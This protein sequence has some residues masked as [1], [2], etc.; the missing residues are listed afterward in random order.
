MPR[1]GRPPKPTELRVLEGNPGRRP[2]NDAEPRFALLQDV[3]PP[4]WL[5]E[6]ARELWAYLVPRLAAQRVLTEI[7]LPLLAAACERWSVYRRAS[8]RLTRSLTQ[9]TRAVGRTALPEVNISKAA[10]QG[11]VEL[12]REFAIGPSSRS[13]VKTGGTGE[14]PPEEPL[15]A[16]RRRG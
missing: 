16:L 5:D 7:D 8:K 12:L 1:T 11:A 14:K 4:P 15:E 9:N 2:L 13:K 6:H 10:L 3:E